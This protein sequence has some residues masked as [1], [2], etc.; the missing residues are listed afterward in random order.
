M[1][2]QPIF[3]SSPMGADSSAPD[4]GWWPRH[5]QSLK[6]LFRMVFGV[7]WLIDGALKF[8]AGFV[9]AFAGKVSPAGQPA[10]L[11]GWFTFWSGQVNGDPAFWVYLVGTFELL[12]GLALLF[13][14]VRKVAYVCGAL[15]SLFIWAVPEGFGGPYGPGS[16]DIGTGAVYALVFLSLLLLNATYGPSRWSLDALIERRVPWWTK[17]AELRN[18]APR[19][20]AG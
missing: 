19:P 20:P 5:A 3:Y 10:W 6:T 2:F 13:G 11:Q 18:R 14:F 12:L 1:N 15:L 16:T 8:S 9:D 17:L 4:E 7:V